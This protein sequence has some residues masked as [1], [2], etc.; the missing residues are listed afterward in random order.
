M[1]PVQHELVENIGKSN[2]GTI[3]EKTTSLTSQTNQHIEDQVVV[4]P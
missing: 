1:R 4:K 3:N 2:T